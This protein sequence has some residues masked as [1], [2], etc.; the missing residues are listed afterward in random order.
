MAGTS[1]HGT[2]G[3]GTAGGQW[4]HTT[5]EQIDQQRPCVLIIAHILNQQYSHQ[6]PEKIPDGDRGKCDDHKQQ[7]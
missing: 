2:E 3:M 7:C 5:G 1:R 6:L 4:V